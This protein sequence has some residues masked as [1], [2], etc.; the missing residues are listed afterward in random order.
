[1]CFIMKKLSFLSLKNSTP[2]QDESDFTHKINYF[3]HIVKESPLVRAM[4]ILS[5]RTPSSL[6][7]FRHSNEGYSST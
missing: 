6:A 3:K 1:M 7:A 2:G 4:L 5:I